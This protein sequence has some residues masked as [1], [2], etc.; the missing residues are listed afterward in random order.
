MGGFSFP[1]V[2]KSKQRC[3]FKINLSKYKL[4]SSW[5]VSWGKVKWSTIYKVKQNMLCYCLVLNSTIL[6]LILISVGT[7]SGGE[8]RSWAFPVEELRNSRRTVRDSSTDWSGKHGWMLQSG[9][10]CCLPLYNSGVYQPFSVA[11]KISEC[12]TEFQCLT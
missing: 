4:P 8:G 2:F 6:W 12:L 11:D 9:L 10:H 7:W 5:N 1:W 3:F